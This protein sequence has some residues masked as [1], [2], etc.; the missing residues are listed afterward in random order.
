MAQA[1]SEP[2]TAD[3]HRDPLTP[4]M[5]QYHEIKS[6]Y[7]GMI[8]MFRLG[9]FYEMFGEDAQRASRILELVLTRRQA[10]PMCGVPHHASMTYIKR[11][12]AA[13]EKVAVCEQLEE[14]GPG[15]KIVRRGVTRVITP[16]TILDDSLL[17][18]KQNN[19]L[20]CVCPSRELTFF[21]LAYADIST[22]ECCAAEVT[23]AQL[24]QELARIAPGE[25]LV[26][27]AFEHNE[28]LQKFTGAAGL[29]PVDDWHFTPEEARTRVTGFF[30]LQSLAPL[31]LEDRTL[32]CAAVAGILSY[33]Q[34]TQCGQAP[35]L[36]PV[37]FYSLDNYLLLDRSAVNNLEL[38]EGLAT[39]TRENSLLE[40]MDQ[41]V[42]PMGSRRLKQWLTQ[43]LLSPALIAARQDC[44]AFFID[45]ST[46]R[47]T[48]RDLLKTA[49]DIERIISRVA[50]RTASPRDLAALR[51]TLAL[52]DPLRAT[53]TA[54]PGFTDAPPSIARLATG[55][56]P[57]DNTITRIAGVLADEPPASLKDG[58]VIKTGYNTALD[59]LR[60]ISSD[61]RQCIA[62]MESAER[63][64][65]GI[66]NLKIGY[67]SV[68]GYYIEISKSN[69]QLVPA[70][71]TRKQTVA[72]GERFITPELKT[73]EEKVLS[74]DEKIV[75]LEM[76]LFRELTAAVAADAEN[77]LALGTVISTLDVYG[78][79]AEIA[80]NYNYVRPRIDESHT[81][82][83]REGRH[84]V[85]E[86]TL[87]AGT[88]VPNDV[89]LNG[90]S[91]Q[92]ILLTGPNMAG[93]STYLRQAA[94]LVI[95]AQM[96]SFVPAQEAD[97]GIVDRIFTRIGAGDNL[98]LGESTFMV[99]MHE[100]ARILNQ[101]TP[102]SLI[103]LDEVGRGTS[104]YDGISIAW[105]CVEFLAG[106]RT[107]GTGPNV[108][109]ATH[110]FELTDLEGKYPG[111]KNC[112]VAVKEWN[113]GVVFLHKIV[114]GGADR[115]YGI[116]VAKL[117]GLPS[118]V[119]ASASAIMR[120]LERKSPARA[121]RTA[122][123]DLPL[124]PSF[125]DEFLV[126]LSA[127]DINSL[128]PLQALEK[129]A[130][131]QKTFRR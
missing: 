122:E 12:V 48:I 66:A 72:N 92:I 102:R 127:I 3:H 65:T 40:I 120:E 63:A 57:A 36:M 37:R 70:T 6:Q 28:S 126:E 35:A 62:A 54:V 39:R 14:P 91:D 29:T 32:A 113:N 60:A 116:H 18:T 27:G 83:I 100:T 110:Y 79:L 117:A 47:R 10:V 115:S 52:V 53:L 16:G 45:E 128:T 80:V 87:K 73:F 107:R 17:E 68:F 46:A 23:P 26:P 78:A 1:N 112:N 51:T 2:Q 84:P 99:E 31:G 50:A 93:K 88:F 130:Q 22:G 121:A 123:P 21:G 111:V 41:T 77:I 109:F 61:T 13:G 11:L 74:A 125:S 43:P 129:L 8:L 49:S 96:G 98:S 33:V 64:R 42:T 56:A 24:A 44:V 85:I 103:I 118:V 86:R 30:H 5:R 97:I 75:R 76:E 105:A 71:Y 38:V 101:L 59:E 19:W 81:L 94:L 4:L 131:L 95:M 55:L 7:P 20:A 82:A 124:F 25:L 106:R 67:T 108:L 104:T 114:P 90:D 15:K 58:G 34:K 89:F 69:L 119:I 9:D